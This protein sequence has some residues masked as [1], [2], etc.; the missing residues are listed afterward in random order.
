MTNCQCHCLSVLEV[1]NEG[2]DVEGVGRDVD[3]LDIVVV[4]VEETS[5]GASDKETPLQGF[6]PK[7]K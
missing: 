5:F 3:M 2:N 7:N 4:I 6:A 1:P